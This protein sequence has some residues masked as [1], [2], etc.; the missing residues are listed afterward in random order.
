V[1]SSTHLCSTPDWSIDDRVQN[2][3]PTMNSPPKMEAPR[4]SHALEGGAIRECPPENTAIRVFRRRRLLRRTGGSTGRTA[5]VVP[6]TVSSSTFRLG[7][8]AAG[9]V[10]T[11]RVTT[12]GSADMEALRSGTA[13][14]QQTGGLSPRHGGTRMT[15]SRGDGLADLNLHLKALA[16]ESISNSLAA[17]RP[18]DP[19]EPEEGGMGFLGGAEMLRSDRLVSDPRPRA[20]EWPKVP[21]G[22][23]GDF[24][25]VPPSRETIISS[26]TD[27][28]DDSRQARTRLRSRGDSRGG[29][30]M[31]SPRKVPSPSI[32]PSEVMER[33]RAVAGERGS[34]GVPGVTG[35][36]F[37]SSP[38]GPSAVRLPSPEGSGGV[39]FPPDVRSRPSTRSGGPSERHAM[40]L[41]TTPRER[42]KSGK[43]RTKQ[44]EGGGASS[45]VLAKMEA[46]IHKTIKGTRPASRPPPNDAQSPP[47]SRVQSG[48][49]GNAHTPEHARRVRSA[50]RR[51]DLRTRGG[52]EEPVEAFADTTL[53]SADAGKPLPSKEQQPSPQRTSKAPL[54]NGVLYQSS[55]RPP[56]RQRDPFPTLL[57][58]LVGSRNAF[59][60]S[61][62]ARRVGVLPRAGRRPQ[63]ANSG[64]LGPMTEGTRIVAMGSASRQSSRQSDRDS[65]VPPPR[66]EEDSFGSFAAGRTSTRSGEYSSI[67]RPGSPL[68]DDAHAVRR[69]EQSRPVRPNNALLPQDRSPRKSTD[70]TKKHKNDI[71]SPISSKRRRAR[72]QD[73]KSGPPVLKEALF[74]RI[75]PDEE[76]LVPAPR[77]AVEAAQLAGK[78]RPESSTGRRGT[79]KHLSPSSSPKLSE[80]RG[81][82]DRPS[83]DQYGFSGMPVTY[84][85][86]IS[87]TMHNRIPDLS[88][89]AKTRAGR[90]RMRTG[91]ESTRPSVGPSPEQW[92]QPTYVRTSEPGSSSTPTHQGGRKDPGFR[93]RP[94]G[95]PSEEEG[96]PSSAPASRT[97]SFV[98]DR[99]SLSPLIPKDPADI[100]PEQ[101]SSDQGKP[102]SDGGLSPHRQLAAGLRMSNLEDSVG[103]SVSVSL[104]LAATGVES[105][106][107]SPLHLHSPEEQVW[108]SPFATRVSRHSESSDAS[109]AGRASLGADSM[110]SELTVSSFADTSVNSGE[111]GTPKKLIP[112][113]PVGSTLDDGFLSLFASPSK[114]HRLH[115]RAGPRHVESL[116][117]VG[118]GEL[119]ADA[120]DDEEAPTHSRRGQTSSEQP[121]DSTHSEPPGRGQLLVHSDAHSSNRL[122]LDGRHGPVR[123][124]R[125]SAA[126]DVEEHVRLPALRS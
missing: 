83:G 45:E 5:L 66:E 43:R 94:L 116:M 30:R 72:L 4:V 7:T 121:L 8:S 61:P 54:V 74:Q 14:I 92:V 57:A 2:A 51:G 65:S 70:K 46:A 111:S 53:L 3:R 55:L 18:F 32:R 62:Y 68:E 26:T 96:A 13:P 58:D 35:G 88:R 124:G 80:P 97:A 37:P 78:A 81:H 123:G 9:A 76:A 27:I 118:G 90:P 56:S 98:F 52:T 115:Q 44:G 113:R 117:S 73:V 34:A 48:R 33:L 38:T 23:A 108:T 112:A 49:R 110:A 85:I 84:D 63:H 107:H 126:W 6:A 60:D 64:M 25:D 125:P 93:V 59:A 1:G 109:D 47:R 42:V 79:A 104:E 87:V 12:N 40:G 29:S 75:V 91:E 10:G 22:I 89:R 15:V 103:G 95:N 105:A 100:S 86:P 102:D 50:M 122:A 16:A 20:G 28:S 69:D 114:L 31:A 24:G 71:A 19:R 11:S 41:P 36:V 101:P 39:L 67:S 17:D 106:N 120:E 82:A 21:G 119:P 99:D 77:E